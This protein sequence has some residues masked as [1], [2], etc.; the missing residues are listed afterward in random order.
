MAKIVSPK[1]SK[2]LPAFVEEQKME[3]LLND[4]GFSD[5]YEGRL[6]R[7]VIE[8]L[9][10][11][12][13]RVSELVNLKRGDVDF[14]LHHLKVLG[15]GNKTR[16]IP[17]SSPSEQLLQGW[18]QEA[19]AGDYLLY[20]AKGKKLQPRMVYEIVTKALGTVTTQDKKSPHVLRHTFATHLLNHGADLNA[21]KELLGHANLAATQVYTHNSIDKLRS[22]HKRAHPRG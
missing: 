17:L 10:M 7:M 12:G 22:I 14:S 16:W 9:Y 15:K 11:T 1:N 19:A 18:M 5:S 13:M 3:H 2:R 20:S 6:S 21:I 8:L 4:I